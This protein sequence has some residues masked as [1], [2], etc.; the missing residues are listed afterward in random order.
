MEIATGRS[1]GHDVPTL[2]SFDW[3]TI[4]IPTAKPPLPEAHL[5]GPGESEV[6]WVALETPGSCAVL[7]EVPARGVAGQL[8]VAFTGTLGLLLD[9]KQRG[10]IPA[11]APVLEE[12]NRHDFRMA[13]R[14]REI[15]LRRAGESP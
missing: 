12:L 1:S 8:G 5:L 3:I 11:V 9:A 7:D 10:L 6:V 15:L 13:P 2:S 14:L 4:R